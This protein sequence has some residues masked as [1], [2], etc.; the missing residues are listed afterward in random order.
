[1]PKRDRAPEKMWAELKPLLADAE[2]TTAEQR[3]PAMADRRVEATQALFEFHRTQAWRR[4][5]VRR[6]GEIMRVAVTTFIETVM[7]RV[8]TSRTPVREL[9]RLLGELP[10]P[11][12]K[13]KSDPDSELELA[14]LV[15]RAV[16]AEI[17]LLKDNGMTEDGARRKANVT[18]ACKKVAEGR[19]Q[20][21]ERVRA[22]YYRV[23][24]KNEEKSEH[25]DRLTA[26]ED[27]AL[28][29]WRLLVDRYGP[30]GA[31]ETPSSG[32]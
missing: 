30:D 24:P 1:M 23:K 8:A 11:K 7:N 3:D 18:A 10:R 6:E 28:R 26:D 29:L 27:P 31:S 20:S 5:N 9:Q 19:P 4:C 25:Q 12:G 32:I 13:P 17:A 2:L 14:V 16:L 21:P 15:E 22:I